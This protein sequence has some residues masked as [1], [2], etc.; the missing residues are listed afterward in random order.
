MLHIYV[1]VVQVQVTITLNVRLR[2]SITVINLGFINI[3]GSWGC[4]YNYYKF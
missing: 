4:F 3:K 1:I 2:E